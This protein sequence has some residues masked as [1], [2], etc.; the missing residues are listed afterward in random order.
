MI[1]MLLLIVVWQNAGAIEHRLVD[2]DRPV[3]RI[4]NIA[5]HLHREM[6]DKFEINKENHLLVSATCTCLSS[7]SYV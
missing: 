5:I 4:P 1:V 3:L 2:I 6:N 7:F